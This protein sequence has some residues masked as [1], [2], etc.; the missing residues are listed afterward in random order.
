MSDF[1]SRRSVVRAQ[2]GIVAASQ[3]LAS[4]AGLQMLLKGGNAIDAAIATAMGNGGAPV[5]W[6][7][8]GSRV[9]G[10]VIA[11]PQGDRCATI[12]L[13]VEFAGEV[14]KTAAQRGCMQGKAWRTRPQKP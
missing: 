7:L 11:T 14:E 8:S 10:R 1:P 3:T 12:V 6:G 5:T 2:N 9:Q 13:E 4:V